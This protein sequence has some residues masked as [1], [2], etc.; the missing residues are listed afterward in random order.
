M[1]FIDK[2]E[3]QGVQPWPAL[4]KALQGNVRCMVFPWD[5]PETFCLAAAEAITLGIPVIARRVGALPERVE[6][7]KT[8]LLADSPKALAQACIRL[9]QD[10]NAASFLAQGCLRDT[11]HTNWAKIAER[12]EKTVL[13]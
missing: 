8:G 4:I 2:P 12:W 9:L 3:H 6:E 7:G 1:A 10:D 13:S 5:K 11:L